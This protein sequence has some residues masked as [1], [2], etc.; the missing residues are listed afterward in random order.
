MENKIKILKSVLGEFFRDSHYRDA[1]INLR[2]SL[3]K[4]N[5]Y[6]KNWTAIIKMILDKELDSGLPIKL[7]H[8]SANS[9]LDEDSEEEAYKWF[10]LMLIN[11]SGFNDEK[12]IDY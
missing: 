11:S 1:I 12:I 6:S 8:D 4:D 7:I 5:L 3:Q 10:Y 9:P 2:K